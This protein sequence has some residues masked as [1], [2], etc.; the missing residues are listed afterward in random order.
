MSNWKSA[1][2]RRVLAAL[3]RTGWRVKRQKGS[4]KT[5]ERLGYADYVFSF[6]DGEEIGSKMMARI[7]KKTGLKPGDI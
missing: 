4:H 7:A 1:K 6:H 5:L 2:A 3:E